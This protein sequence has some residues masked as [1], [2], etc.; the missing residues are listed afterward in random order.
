MVD[1]VHAQDVFS[2]GEL[3]PTM[4]ARVTTT[5]YYKGLKKAKNV[6]PIPQGGARKRW[7]TKRTAILNQTDYTKIRSMTFEYLSEAIYIVVF[8]DNAIDIWLEGRLIATVAATGIRTEDLALMD[9][10]VIENKLRVTTGVY[11]PKD[12]TRS[13]NAANIIAGVDTVNDYIQLTTATTNDFILPIRFTTAGTLPTT[14]PQ[15][16]TDRT[17]FFRAFSTTNVAI[18]TNIDDAANDVNRYDVTA[19]GAGVSNVIIL[20]TWTFP[21]VAFK[22]Y[23]VH[24]FTGGYDAITFTPGATTGATTL[25]AS[26]PIFTAGHVGGLFFSL[27]GG[28]ARITGFTS[29][30]VVNIQV[31]FPFIGIAAVSGLFCTL[32]E[33]AW[34]NAR[35]WPKLVSSYQNRAFFANTDLLP[36]GLWGST[37]N[38]FE[39]FDDSLTDDDNAISWFPTSDIGNEISFITPFKSLVVHTESGVYST[40]MGADTAIT[41]KN[42]S[43][44]LQD[45][46]PTAIMQPVIIDNQ[47]IVISGVDVHSLLYD[48]VQSGYTPNIVSAISEHLIIDPIDMEAFR[49]RKT[50]G[51]RYVF[52]VNRD[53][54]LAMYQTLYSEEVSGWTPA[55]TEQYYGNAYFRKVLSSVNGRCWFIV[56]RQIAQAGVAVNITGFDQGDDTLEAVATNFSTTDPTA[57]LFTTTG[58]LPETSPQIVTTKYYF[59][60]GTSADDFRTYAN[61][62]DALNDENV[63]Q[64][65]DA[66]VNSKVA[67]YPLETR[68]FLEELS[69]DVFTDCTVIQDGAGLTNL[70]GLGIFNGNLV[71]VKADGRKFDSNPVLAGIEAVTAMG[72][73]TPVDH[74]ETGFKINYEVWPMP[75]SVSLG[76]SVNTSNLAQAKHIKYVNAIF[77]NSIGGKIN[78]QNI[79]LTR[80]GNFV[81]DAPEPQT[82]IFQVSVMGGWNEDFNTPVFRITQDDP[83]PFTLIGLFYGV[84]V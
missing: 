42:F 7:G 19:A 78:N 32:T 6:L 11:K 18:Y 22:F 77:A 24:D 47:V 34:S 54:S 41:P 37:I 65:I 40:P 3:S 80:L 56:E 58:T 48:F 81:F 69:Y 61:I 13:A 33:P 23:P 20:N 21:D 71:T 67:P 82:G 52:I 30:T 1:Y 16:R 5:V 49:D 29:T 75:I 50:T 72:V 66:G 36:N 55:Y 39:D 26:A 10:S 51:G 70:T 74:A 45:N 27:D 62:E 46:T 60:I 64:I 79:A 43:L 9:W 12:L 31:V 25:T 28:I 15:I 68:L 63:I 44:T 14:V 17:Y 2:K 84:D 8:Y 38:D 57:V 59:V 4:Y 35:G 83:F 53:G 73:S 76:Q